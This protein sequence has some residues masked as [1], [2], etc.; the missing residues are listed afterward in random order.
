LYPLNTEQQQQVLSV[1][2]SMKQANKIK[3]NPTGLFIRLAQA[4]FREIPYGSG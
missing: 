1:F 2:N 4:A 3:S